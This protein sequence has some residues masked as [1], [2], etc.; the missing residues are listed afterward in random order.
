MTAAEAHAEKMDQ[1]RANIAATKA[2]TAATKA[3]RLRTRAA[4]KA[5]EAQ[6]RKATR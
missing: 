3:E 1:L 6:I 5:I 4:R 2:K